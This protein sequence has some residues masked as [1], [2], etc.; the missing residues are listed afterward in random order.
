MT[1]PS[2][3]VDTES[4]S[5]KGIPPTREMVA[6]VTVRTYLDQLEEMVRS[7]GR[8]TIGHMYRAGTPCRFMPDK[9]FR[10]LSELLGESGRI[11][12]DDVV[13]S[14]I[15]ALPE[16]QRTLKELGLKLELEQFWSDE[17]RSLLDSG[18]T[19]S[20]ER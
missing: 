1:D 6:H 10:S 3:D 11:V 17:P 16:T 4:L 9:V 18:I 13:F 19:V 12:S 14:W 7:I 2:C 8:E 15:T 20:V 5:G